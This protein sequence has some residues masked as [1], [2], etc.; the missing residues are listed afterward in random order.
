[1]ASLEQRVYDADLA[2]Q[3]LENEAFHRAFADIEEEYT[4]AWKQSPA[5]DP[6]GREKIYLTIR[7]LQRLKLTLEASLTDGKLA[8][9]EMEHKQ[10]LLDQAKH[11]LGMPL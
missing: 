9:H 7:L 2:R 5:R 10:G 4:E 3:V 11:A 6:E 1:M 8:K